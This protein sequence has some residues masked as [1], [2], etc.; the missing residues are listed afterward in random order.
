MSDP[1]SAQLRDTLATLALGLR[2]EALRAN[3]RRA[4]GLAGDPDWG[5]EAARA[6]LDALAP[7]ETAWVSDRPLPFPRLALDAGTRLL[8]TEVD[9]LVY[10]AH[11][12]FDPDGFGA[13]VGALR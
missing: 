1:F 13:A 11:S 2:Q 7:G 5:I 6:A 9:C 10:D 4:L 8:G 3:Q 12:G